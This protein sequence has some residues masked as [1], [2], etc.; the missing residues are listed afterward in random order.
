MRPAPTPFCK[1]GMSEIVGYQDTLQGLLPRV[2]C[3]EGVG[4]V[5]QLSGFWG[6]VH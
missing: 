6:S 2:V 4:V 3:C 5:V 1:V